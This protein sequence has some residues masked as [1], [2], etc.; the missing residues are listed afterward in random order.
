[1]L[2]QEDELAELRREVEAQKGLLRSVM[3][4]VSNCLALVAQAGLAL[5]RSTDAAGVDA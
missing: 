4:D 3:T 1:M 5:G 2:A